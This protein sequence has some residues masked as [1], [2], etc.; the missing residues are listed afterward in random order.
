MR[1]RILG[2]GGSFGVPLIGNF[3]GNCK[4][5]NKK[6]Y[7]L[8]PSILLYYKQKNILIDTSPDL[9]LQLLN[10]KCSKIDAVLYT[11][12]H[13]DHVH[14]I[15]DLRAISL[16]MKKK[17]PAWG[18]IQTINYLK[19]SFRYIFD[20]NLDNKKNTDKYKKSDY[21]NP[22][23]NLNK[24]ENIFK[25]KNIK[26]N[27]FQHNHGDIDCTTYRIGDFAYT[28]DIKYFYDND[29]DKLKG[30]KKWIVG[31]LRYDS[32]PSHANFNQILEFVN[33]LKPKKT[34]LT[35]L[36]GWLDYDE[37]LKKCPKNV[38][39]AFDGLEFNVK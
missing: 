39:P 15:N 2:C 38:E 31:C 16:I 27:S 8:R 26:I 13:A 30:V 9:R 25:F 19:D 24:I 7:R 11:H 12:K 36:T 4:K 33:Y 20:I 28:T 6:N 18:S 32:H 21:Y 3:F 34:Y 5:T 17:I 14:G 1:I 22:I 29:I 35:H 10:A 23:M 37:L